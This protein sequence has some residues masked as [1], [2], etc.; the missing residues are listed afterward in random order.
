MVIV[1][2]NGITYRVCMAD[3]ITSACKNC[4][5]AHKPLC[6]EGVLNYYLCNSYN[7]NGEFA[8]FKRID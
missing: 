2:I 5:F 4:S 3:S 1:K 8:Y 7:K 6:P